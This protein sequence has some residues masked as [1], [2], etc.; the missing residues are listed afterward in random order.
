MLVIGGHMST[1][2]RAGP[3]TLP[4]AYPNIF[5]QLAAERGVDAAI[6]L[7]RAGLEGRRLADPAGRVSVQE[8]IHL[9]A[10]TVELAGE[11]GLGIEAGLRQPLT[12]HGSLG[13]AMMCSACIGDGLALLQRFWHLRARGIELEVRHE[14]GIVVCQ[15][16]QT[17]PMAEPVRRTLLASMLG[18]FHQGMLFALG[19][20]TPGHEIW[21]DHPEP[22]WFARYRERLPP[23][24]FDMPWAQYRLPVATL[25]HP[26]ATAS[27]EALATAIGLC[28]READLLNERHDQI[29]AAARA[30]LIPGADGYPAPALLADR[31]HLS[32][33]TL[34][35]RLHEQGSSYQQ[36]LED[37]RHR[38]AL[39]LLQHPGLEIRDIA[40]R[41]GYTDP[42]NFTR[43]FRHWT[44]HAPSHYREL[45]RQA[46]GH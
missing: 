20:T 46:P 22:A 6:V 30:A 9:A 17:E 11:A 15:F 25:A 29:V 37:A 44:G 12:L 40:A 42:A 4:V 23:A 5:L 10:A 45:L 3:A 13:V 7:A 38:D 36:L 43:A 8:F 2:R 16:R 35:R 21:L 1:P 32:P 33:R 18:S 39:Q 34:R 31:L 26:Q 28:Q 19:G 27:P 41:L 24:R 14:A